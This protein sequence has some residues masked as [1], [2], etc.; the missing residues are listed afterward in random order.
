MF[1]AESALT[2][3]GIDC[4][5]ADGT[6]QVLTVQECTGNNAATCGTTEAAITCDADGQTEATGIDDS[7]IDAGDYIRI[8][9]GT[10][11]GSVTQVNLC[12]T[13]TWD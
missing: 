7:A 1:R 13:F 5:V 11:T 6:S 10:N 2:V 3:T 4:I 9:A 8:L 12:V